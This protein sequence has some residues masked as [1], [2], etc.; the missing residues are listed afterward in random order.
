MEEINFKRIITIIIILL[1]AVLSFFVLKP[2]LLS[3]TFGIILAYIFS[4]MYNLVHK[5]TKSKNFSATFVCIFPL[6]IIVLL[7][8]FFTPILINQAVRLYLA[9][10]QLD[11]LTPLKA[12]FPSLS[13]SDIFLTETANIFSSFVVKTTD[14]IV[15]YVTNILFNLPTISLQLIV[16]FFTLFFVLRDKDEIINVVK[17][18]LPFSEAVNKK[19]F[20]YAKGI[21]KA[22]IYGEVVVGLI[23][24]IIIGAAFF[25]FNV[26]NALLYTILAIIAGVLPIIGTMVIWLPI[27]IYL[28]IQG[29][30][31]SVIGILVFGLI[32]S[33]I[34]SILK[35]L[36]VSRQVK[37]PSSIILIGMIGGVFFFGVLGIIL[38]PL[39]LAYFLIAIESY[40]SK[41][42]PQTFKE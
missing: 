20:D 35:P 12:I 38:G 34:D 25:I 15:S 5:L 31:T 4:P 8:W 13:S 3:I 30:T 11:F 22:V 24:G 10:Q 41:H 14:S 32:S 29:N 17:S 26:P 28:L 37:V 23:Q 27:L 40:I 18:V 36:I 7:I 2:L 1:L 16:V 33:H 19:I 42:A 39:V 9:S 6:V 21:T